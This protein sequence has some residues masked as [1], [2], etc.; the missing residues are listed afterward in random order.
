MNRFEEAAA[1]ARRA[2]DLGAETP[3]AHLILGACA[4]EMGDA[5]TAERELRTCLRGNPGWV[6]A[7]YRLGRA[8][9]LAGRKEEGEKEVARSA[10]QSRLA[11]E[12]ER[13]EGIGQDYLLERGPADPDR[14]EFLE[15]GEAIARANLEA[16]RFDVAEGVIRR[17]AA[18]RPGE[19]GL[20]FLLGIALLGQGRREDALAVLRDC[21]ERNPGSDRVREAIDAIGESGIDSQ[22]GDPPLDLIEDL[23]GAPPR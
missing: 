8:L 21:L 14:R 7:R 2:T 16:L 1:A 12:I 3:E 9:V 6:E 22:G 10:R 5:S 11:L 18:V 13:L 15:I 4:A 19:E 20:S 23:L 17:T